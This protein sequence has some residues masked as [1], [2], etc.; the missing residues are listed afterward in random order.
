[1]TILFIAGAAVLFLG[2]LIGRASAGDQLEEHLERARRRVGET[3]QRRSRANGFAELTY[4]EKT[5]AAESDDAY[6]LATQLNTARQ[7]RS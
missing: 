7:V 2:I 3:S 4:S 5:A 1:M 6:F